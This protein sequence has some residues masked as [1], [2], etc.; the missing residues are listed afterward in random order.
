MY[1]FGWFLER[2][3]CQRLHVATVSTTEASPLP[4]PPRPL[5]LSMAT[6][7]A[8]EVDD[9]SGANFRYTSRR[10]T[11]S[12]VR[13]IRTRAGGNWREAPGRGRSGGDSGAT[14]SPDSEWRRP[15]V[16]QRPSGQSEAQWSAT[17]W[18]VTK[19]SS[20]RWPLV[21][22]PSDF[23]FGPGQCTGGRGQGAGVGVGAGGRGQGQG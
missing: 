10:A 3:N 14:G 22:T 4:L 8:S 17:Q 2:A 1:K 13:V 11:V 6:F 7:G 20:D 15:M 12:R 18:S 23:G 19:S 16:S 5:P 21:L 9:K